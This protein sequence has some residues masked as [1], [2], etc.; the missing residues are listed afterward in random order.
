ML[1]VLIK[2]TFKTLWT[3]GTTEIARWQSTQKSGVDIMVGMLSLQGVRN[4]LSLLIPRR[5]L[6]I[7][8]IATAN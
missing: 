6:Q 7:P 5:M 8:D 2:H 3:Y 4:E 1:P